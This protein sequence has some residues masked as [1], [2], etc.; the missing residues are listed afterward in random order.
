MQKNWPLPSLQTSRWDSRG[1]GIFSLMKLWGRTI[2]PKTQTDHLMQPVDKQKRSQPTY[3]NH[4]IHD[5]R[6]SSSP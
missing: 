1:V 3:N 2:P 6:R 4:E 5:N